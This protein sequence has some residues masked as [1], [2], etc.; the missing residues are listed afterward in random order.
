MAPRTTPH[1]FV[2]NKGTLVYSGA[3]DDGGFKKAGDRNYVSEVVDALLR[4]EE[5]RRSARPSRTAARSSTPSGPA[6]RA[7][8]G[9]TAF[10]GVC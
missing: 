10:S 9:D 7:C 6:N 4:D 2:I 5:R 8:V 3:F 1:M